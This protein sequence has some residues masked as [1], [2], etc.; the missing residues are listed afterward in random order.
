MAD[1]KI[2][3]VE[4]KKERERLVALVKGLKETG[5][6]QPLPNGWTVGVAL[7]HLA[8]WDLSQVA[9]LRRWKDE[10]VK[11]VSIDAEAINGPLAALSEGIPPR[12]VAKLV[13]EAAESVDRIVESLTQEEA[14]E[15]IEM[16]LERN[17]RRSLHRQNHLE[18]IEKALKV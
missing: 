11:P 4:N 1:I 9:R 13:V 12:A 14:D 5:F 2:I 7:A 3:N 18:K 8:F 10:G 15:L 6:A 17:I 16:G